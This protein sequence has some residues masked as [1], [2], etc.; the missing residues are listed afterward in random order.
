MMPACAPHP[1]ACQ[2]VRFGQ[3]P[4]RF[5]PRFLSRCLIQAQACGFVKNTAR[6]N[7]YITRRSNTRHSLQVACTRFSP[8]NGTSLCAAR[9][10]AGCVVPH[11]LSRFLCL[12]GIALLWLDVRLSIKQA[13]EDDERNEVGEE[14]L[15]E[16][17]FEARKLSYETN[18]RTAPP[19]WRVAADSDSWCLYGA[20]QAVKSQLTHPIHTW[21]RHGGSKMYLYA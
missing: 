5:Q 6:A 9:R 7:C 11:K 13:E 15:R 17:R 10:G 18:K 1:L 16:G 3:I 19:C 21:K 20:R 14:G 8:N 12:Y 2:I 4:L